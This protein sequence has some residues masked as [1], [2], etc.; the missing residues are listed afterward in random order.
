MLHSSQHR[1]VCHYQLKKQSIECN[2]SDQTV[3]CSGSMWFNANFVGNTTNGY[4]I[5]KY[6]PFDYCIYGEMNINLENPDAQCAFNHSGVLC[7]GCKKGFSLALGS[8]Q[9]IHCS[10]KYLVVVIPFI[11]AGFIL[12]FFLTFLNLAV[13]Q[14][15]I[16]GLIFYANI[17]KANQ[18]AFFPPGD[19]NI[20]TVFI[21]WLN[22]DPV[23][24]HVLLMV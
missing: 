9:C 4:I 21:A 17:V 20:L 23:L 2:I 6:C 22:L 11:L 3:H 8:S 12:V 10:N 14:G 7:G 15:T 1:C 18:A 5:H 24:R 13:S 16:N 19:T